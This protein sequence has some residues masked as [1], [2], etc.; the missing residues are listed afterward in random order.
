M[1]LSMCLWAPKIFIK[2][3][4]ILHPIGASKTAFYIHSLNVSFGIDSEWET[5]SE[6]KFVL[7]QVR[8]I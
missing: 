8:Y 1:V 3:P 5:E 7:A 2:I 6:C 4:E